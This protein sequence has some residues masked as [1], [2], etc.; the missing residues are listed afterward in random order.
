MRFI[1]HTHTHTLLLKI[2]TLEREEKNFL[3]LSR[4]NKK[5]KSYRHVEAFTTEQIKLSKLQY[6]AIV[7]LYI[8]GIY[9]YRFIVI[10][11]FHYNILFYHL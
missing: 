11:F 10:F 9:V 7:F 5:I 4:K 2:H 1:W 6:F 3:S 8:I